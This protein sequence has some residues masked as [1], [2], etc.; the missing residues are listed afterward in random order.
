M[1]AKKKAKP[2]RIKPLKPV[3]PPKPRRPS[4]LERWWAGM[5]AERRRGIVRTVVCVVLAAALV[6]GVVLGL[7]ALERRILRTPPDNTPLTLSLPS[8]PGW[9]PRELG[10][11][12]VESL[13]PEGV[14][15]FDP[16]AVDEIYRR[17]RAN[18]WIRQVNRIQKIRHAERAGGLVQL[19]LDFRRPVA[20]VEDRQGSPHFVDNEGCVLPE[21][22]VPRWVVTTPGHNG[23]PSIQTTYLPASPIPTDRGLAEIH[24]VTIRGVAGK[25]P[26]IGQ[27]WPGDDLLEG[28]KLVALVSTRH[29]ANQI[30]E[31]DVRNH[32]G[33]ISRNQPHLRMLAR[34]GRLAPT[35]IWFGRFPVDS[36]DYEVPTSRK[37]ELLDYTAAANGGRL[38]GLKGRIDL[39]YDDLWLDLDRTRV[40]DSLRR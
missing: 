35:E 36:A 6:E 38:I 13:V 24:Y 29:Y 39:R 9:M 3:K 27:K 15:F 20:R 8:I 2:E 5:T 1:S 23:Q 28:L 19:D 22:Q 17:C 32:A 30:A 34:V 10:R 31:V 26:P 11:E 4:W 21:H 37:M 33:R 14:G 18:P 16:R 12:I 7:R 40:A 25:A